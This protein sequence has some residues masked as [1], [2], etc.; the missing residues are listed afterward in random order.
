MWTLARHPNKLTFRQSRSQLESLVLERT[1]SLQ[2]LS[3]R[4]LRVQDE[5]RRRVAR[6]LHDSSGQTLTALKLSVGLLQKKLANGERVSDELTG[7]ALLADEALQEIRTTSYLLHPPMLD[8]AGFTSAAQWFV[9]GFAR[10]SGMKVRIEFAPEVERL[11]NPIETALFRVLQESLTNVHRHSGA[12]EV[13][14]RFLREAHA[15]ILEVRDYGR[16]IQQELLSRLGQSVRDS[17][18]GLSGMCERMNELKGDLEITSADPGTRLRAIVP[19][20]SPAVAHALPTQLLTAAATKRA[21]YQPCGTFMARAGK[22]PALTRSAWAALNRAKHVPLNVGRWGTALGMAAVLIISCWIGF[23]DRRPPSL[24]E[25]SGLQGSNAPEQQIPFAPTKRVMANPTSKLQA[26]LGREAGERKTSS[27][28]V[29][30]FSDDVTV[31]YFTPEPT[32]PRVSDR[33]SR[34]RSISEDVTVRYFLPI[35]EALPSNP[36]GSPAQSVSR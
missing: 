33:N 25:V 30:Y 31:R 16:G 29:R 27:I 8:E 28:R 15:V 17:G 7:I 4:L 34:V 12:S 11:P 32:A 21:I 36:N 14:V 26:A 23:S 5:E 10:R 2:R 6:D 24:S 20:S 18:V 1:E 19:L 3:Q 9:E 13:E 35:A 22:M